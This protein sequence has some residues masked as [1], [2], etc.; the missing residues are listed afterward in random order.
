M[1]DIFI[2]NIKP[3]PDKTIKVWF[4]DGIYLEVTPKNSKRWRYKYRHNKKEKLMSLGLYPNVSYEDA[5][6][7]R[8]ECKA[9]LLE[10]IDP[11]KAR[12]IAKQI[13][14]NLKIK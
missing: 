8:C 7:L 5:Y 3:N 6:E 13:Y 1:N 10:G 4:G 12:K 2:K 14:D 9:M 11:S